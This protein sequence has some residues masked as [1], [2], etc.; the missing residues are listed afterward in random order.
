MTILTLNKK[1]LEKEIGKI[2]PELEHKISMFGT[3]IEEIKDNEV[4]VEVFPNRPDL[5]SLQGFTRSFLQHLGKKS[6]SKFNINKPE[7]DYKVKIDKSV[8]QVRPYTV[9]AI[10]KNLKLDDEKIKNIVEI[11]EKLH[12][13]IGRKRTKLAIGIYPLEQIKLPITYKAKKPEDIKFRPLEFPKE[14][15]GKQILSKHPAGREYGNLLKEAEKYP[16]FEDA[17]GKVLSMPPIINSHETGKV[18]EKTKSIFIECSGFNKYYLEKCLNI[19]VS[20]FS[21]MGG[22]IYAMEISDSKKSITPDLE[23]EKLEFSI[24]D[25]NKNLGLELEEKEI[26]RLLEKSGIGIEKQKD[27]TF[28][29]I[30]AYRLDILHWVDLIEEVA[31]NY[32][33]E[34]F[35]PEIPKISTIG[36]ED[37][38]TIKKRKIQEI[39]SGLD[40]IEVS[41]FHLAV[42]KDVKKLHYKF[43]EFIEVED[44]KTEYDVLRPDLLSN[45]LRILSENTSST[46][47]QKIFEIGTCF[48]LN[49][50]KET[51]IKETEKLC[52]ALIGEKINFTDSK[53]ILDYLFKMIDKKYEIKETE[54][55]NYIEGRVGE[56]IVGDKSIGKIGEISPRAIKNFKLKMPIS[57]IE[58]NLDKLM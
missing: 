58:I 19:I 52:I 17:D 34:N 50:S 8:K 57:A 55:S 22:K 36:Q 26:K 1:E 45:L 30:P 20:A 40:L 23:P 7:K 53:Q 16:I 29:L 51:K 2:T 27:K 10:V 46:Y 21:D 41:S 13:T 37:E 56:I 4:S 54:D 12:L 3:P 48:S 33:Y 15:N 24:K 39:L 6:I 18:N 49:D 14:I 35:E 44:S 5:L 47:P 42:K 31:I 9:C 11:Q 38:K 28:A 43:N 32:G 25:L